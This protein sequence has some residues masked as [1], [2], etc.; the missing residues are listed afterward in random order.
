MQS[1]ITIEA[2][3]ICVEQSQY[4]FKFKL[5][6]SRYPRFSVKTLNVHSKQLRFIVLTEA[7]REPPPKPKWTK[8]TIGSSEVRVMQ[9]SSVVKVKVVRAAKLNFRLESTEGCVE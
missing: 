8:S 9:S 6:L 4:H 1:I 5:I 2:P 3:G 7:F